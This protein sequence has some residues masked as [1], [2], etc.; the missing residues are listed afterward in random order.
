MIR[1]YYL[2]DQHSRDS[3][4]RLA[5]AGNEVAIKYLVK[6]NTIILNE[7]LPLACAKATACSNR[8]RGTQCIG[9]CFP[10]DPALEEKN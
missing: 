2:D 9:G 1:Q 5:Q 6:V 10:T 8:K 3:A 7:Y 4:L